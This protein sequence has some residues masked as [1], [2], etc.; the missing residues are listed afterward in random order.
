M[1]PGTQ[2]KEP[3]AAI[4]CILSQGVG[5]SEGCLPPDGEGV[6]VL[7]AF[8]FAMRARETVLTPAEN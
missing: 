1:V 5:L 4:E 7:T 2:G 6:H 3:Q 8:L